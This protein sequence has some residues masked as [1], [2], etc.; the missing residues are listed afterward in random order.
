MP[1]DIEEVCKQ[2][3]K[4]VTPKDPERKKIENLSKKLEMRVASAA[5][6]LGV[7]AKVRVEGSVAK[8]T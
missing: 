3:L 7:K 2:V 5:E 4:Q 1:E 6:E 8:N